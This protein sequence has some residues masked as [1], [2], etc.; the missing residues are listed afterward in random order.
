MRT[1]VVVP[2]AECLKILGK[3]LVVDDNLTQFVLESP[4]EALDATV[5]PGRRDIGTLVFDAQPRQPESEQAGAEDRFV[6]GAD[7]FRDFAG[8]INGVE[9][10]TQ[11]VY[12]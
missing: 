11:E 10:G 4:E 2:I 7:E 8:G 9:Q 5:L 3:V 6:V 12:R 1:N